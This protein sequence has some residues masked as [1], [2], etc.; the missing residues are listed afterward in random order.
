MSLAPI[1]VDPETA[2]RFMRRALMLDS[3]SS[4]VASL[5]SHLGFLQIDPINV[6]GRMHDLI[7]R[8]RVIDYREGDLMRHLHGDGVAMSPKRRVALEHHFPSE[9]ASAGILAA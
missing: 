5:I 2:R 1:D 8:N 4:S 7:A 6:C 3:P 9:G